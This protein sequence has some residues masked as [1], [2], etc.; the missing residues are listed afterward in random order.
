MRAADFLRV[1][2]RREGEEVASHCL[3]CRRNTSGPFTA[4]LLL[5]VQIRKAR[6]R[7]QRVLTSRDVA[8]G[9][10]FG[11]QEIDELHGFSVEES[12]KTPRENNKGQQGAEKFRESERQEK[13]NVG[14]RIER[15]RKYIVHCWK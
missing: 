15:Q 7:R 9:R 12:E 4:L 6:A 11:A 10:R 13:D 5:I 1:L 3:S 8:D 14:E 2:I